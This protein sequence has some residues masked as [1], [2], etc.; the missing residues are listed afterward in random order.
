MMKPVVFSIALD[1]TLPVY[2]I[3]HRVQGEGRYQQFQHELTSIELTVEPSG[4]EG[5]FLLQWETEAIPRHLM[6]RV[7][8]GIRNV[9][10]ELKLEYRQPLSN[11]YIRI[12]GGV[13]STDGLALQRATV[14]AFKD[15]L[16]KTRLVPLLGQK[17]SY[18]GE[19]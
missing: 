15:A 7:I 1:P 6:P 9:A 14:A 17:A 11:I 3:V 18:A 13:A 10:E 8:Q 19:R 16:S 12:Q 2:T 5:Q 4:S